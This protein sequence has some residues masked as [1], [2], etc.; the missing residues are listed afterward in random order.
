MS[1]E[2]F[3]PTTKS[4]KRGWSLKIQV[5]VHI[6]WLALPLYF[7]GRLLTSGAY[8]AS[9]NIA[10]S[11]PDLKRILGGGIHPQWF[12]V[13]SALP[14]YNSDFAEWSVTLSGSAGEGRLYGVANNVGGHWEFSRLTFVAAKDG[15]KIDLTPTPSRLELPAVGAKKVYLI[16]LGLAT[17]QSLNWAPE[18]YRA[19]LG[20]DVEILPPEDMDPSEED[21]ARHQ[22]IAEK[23]VHLIVQSHRDLATDP[24]AILI[25]VTSQDMFIRAY[26]W[27]YAENF[28]EE[29]RLG[30][31]SAAR[32]QPTEYPGKWNKELLNS[33]LEKMLT[34]NI[35]ALYF[36]L[37]LSNDYTSILSAGVLSGNE[38]DY[39]SSRIVG[40][41]G[42]WDPIFVQGDPLV[43]L[44]A[45]PGKPA[46]WTMDVAGRSVPDTRVDF[47]TVDLA[48]GLFIQRKFDFFLDDQYPLAFARV[49]RNNDDRSREFGVGT[50][51]SL[52]IF[53][54]GRMGDSIDLIREDGGRAHFVYT[55]PK[56]G[57]PSQLYLASTTMGQFKQA[58]YGDDGVWRVTSKDGW[59]YIF[60]YRPKAQETQ[61]TVLTGFIDPA[62]RKYDMTRDD[63]GDLLS[64]TTPS[65]KWLHFEHDG[66]HR[67][68]RIQD[69]LGR[70]VQYD[71][72]SRGQLIRVSD[73]EGHSESYTYDDRNEMLSVVDAAGN[74]LLT[75]QYTSGG[76]ITGQ[77]LADGGHFEY[78]YRFETRNVISQSMFTEPNGLIT[79]FEYGP[80]G[81]FQSLPTPPP[82]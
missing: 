12:P 13:G 24:S 77:V 16:P 5:L 26:N 6:L 59:T 27:K 15:S 20:I 71:Y 36:N 48:L 42:R 52:D 51:D 19:K 60:P 29:G 65:G 79:Y 31:V 41:E 23:C 17:E 76:L 75:N 46:I 49:Y 21:Q 81:Y 63:S 61:V 38:V 39:M 14:R 66:G 34:K 62:G 45:A 43:S 1:S 74:P 55:A 53:L 32:L 64:I 58:V 68:R 56:P 50:C 73:S 78:W 8:R 37:P 72:N 80:G 30:I 22:Y 33:R 11:S 54:V 18:Y 28:R 70:V 67:V 4:K 10:K 35:V 25:G 9:I 7:Y 2:P 40:A 82:Q 47:F 44:T 69:S 3:A 57:E